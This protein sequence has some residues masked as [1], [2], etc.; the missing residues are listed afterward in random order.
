MQK[1]ADIAPEWWETVFDGRMWKVVGLDVPGPWLG[2]TDLDPYLRSTYGA[3]A[4]AQ[5]RRAA[6][7]RAKLQGLRMTA[8]IRADQ[9]VMVDEGDTRPHTNSIWC[10][11][12]QVFPT[13]ASIKERR[14]K[15]EDAIA[16]PPFTPATGPRGRGR[17][18]PRAAAAAADQTQVIA[19][20]MA[21]QD[22]DPVPPENLLKHPDLGWYMSQCWCQSSNFRTHDRMCRIYPMLSVME[23]V[24]K[25]LGISPEEWFRR[26][27]I[28]LKW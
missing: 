27:G 3:E 20:L 14:W 5:F 12:L 28:H 8:M 17:G 15:R 9:V 1:I 7:Y 19:R 24:V 18:G 13:D 21:T 6:N 10:C 23:R 2:R 26:Y 22:G 25:R 11:F 16:A 4:C